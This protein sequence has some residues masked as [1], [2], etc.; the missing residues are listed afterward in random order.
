MT[1]RPQSMNLLSPSPPPHALHSG[2]GPRFDTISR[3][4]LRGFINRRVSFRRRALESHS[5]GRDL[6]MMS[7]R[8][9]NPREIDAVADNI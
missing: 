9:I 7:V 3:L 6:E 8:P 1:T 4:S 5:V 2:F